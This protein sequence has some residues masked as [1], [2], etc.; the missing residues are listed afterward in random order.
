MIEIWAVLLPILIADVINPVLF[1]S[2]VYA[3]GTKHPVTNS[4]AIPLGHTL[5]YFSMGLI[6]ALGFE[7]I[8]NPL[9]NPR[10]IDFFIELLIGVL[11]LW[12]AFR[13]PPI[14]RKASG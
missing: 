12:V 10:F 8:P 7:R 2:M 1:A 13:S 9:A 5:A 4:S 3:A 6:L 14:N 11:L